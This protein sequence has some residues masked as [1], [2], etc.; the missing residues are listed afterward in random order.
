MAAKQSSTKYGRRS[1][2][3][4]SGF[5]AGKH[6]DHALGY[7]AA[8]GF[9]EGGG[10]DGSAVDRDGEALSDGSSEVFAG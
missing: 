3:P 8:G 4:V 10:G 7:T 9:V 5:D 2:P 1:R 6:V